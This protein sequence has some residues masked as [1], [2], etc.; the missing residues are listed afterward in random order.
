MKSW[1]IF[2]SVFVA[3]I[4][5]NF[6][7]ATPNWKCKKYE[8]GNVDKK[9]IVFINYADCMPAKC[10]LN[11]TILGML[12]HSMRNNTQQQLVLLVDDFVEI[13]LFKRKN[14]I[15]HNLLVKSF[16]NKKG[17]HVN[18]TMF[19]S[20]AVMIFD[21][22]SSLTY[23]LPFVFEFQMKKNM[24]RVLSQKNYNLVIK[25]AIFATMY[26]NV[27]G[28]EMVSFGLLILIYF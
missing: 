8:I 28:N 22:Y 14:R 19:G 15:G 7:D 10:N 9:V 27:C 12:A 4:V 20:S 13:P 17:L 11:A 26:D 16:G 25:A 23:K 24:S 3:V 21:S 6:L 18:K 2:G 1:I 5:T